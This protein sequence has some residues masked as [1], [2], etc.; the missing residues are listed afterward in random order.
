MIT[1]TDG[2]PAA[3]V[4]LVRLELMFHCNIHEHTDEWTF[5]LSSEGAS[6]ALKAV[7]DLDELGE[8]PP[9]IV[10]SSRAPGKV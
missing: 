5:E 4:T 3:W 10:P 1:M 8:V 6:R 2:A 7:S 9:E